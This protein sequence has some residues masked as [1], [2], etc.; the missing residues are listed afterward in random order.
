ME[1]DQVNRRDFLRTSGA[2]AVAATAVGGL[3]GAPA[4]ARSAGSNQRIRIGF[5]GPGGRGFGAHVKSLA[6]LKKDGA[7]IDLVTAADVYSEYRD[8]AADYIKKETG[9]SVATYV[10]YRDMLAKEKLDAV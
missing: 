2:S 8:R 3:A 7:N 10:D 4:P 6:Q 5:I 1:R 9:T